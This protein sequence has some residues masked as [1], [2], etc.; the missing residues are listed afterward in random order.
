MRHAKQI[1]AVYDLLQLLPE[2]E[3]SALNQAVIVRNKENGQHFAIL[4]TRLGEIVE[5]N[6]SRITPIPGASSNDR[7]IAES[8]VNPLSNDE[9]A[10]NVLVILSID[11]IYR[12][13]SGLQL[14]ALQPGE[15]I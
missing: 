3:G 8:V 12:L 5:I 11:N 14:D 15:V 7:T 2:A 4:V 1:I 9:P 10:S 6:R 13:V